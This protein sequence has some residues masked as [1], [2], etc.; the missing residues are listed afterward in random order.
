MAR[1]KLAPGGVKRAIFLSAWFY[2][3][4]LHVYPASFRRTYGSRMIRVFRDSCRNALQKHGLAGF[5]ILWLST[6]T[7]LLFSAC[8]ERWQVLKEKARSMIPDKQ[9]QNFPLRLWIAIAA[10][11]LAFVVSLVASLN[12]YLLEDASPLT[13]AAYSAS[14]LLRFDI[15]QL[16]V[17][18][19]CSNSCRSSPC[20]T[21]RCSSRS[22]CWCRQYV[23][24]ECRS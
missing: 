15:D 4:F 11:V 12:L 22:L 7:D 14:S 24:C 20:S 6:L 3:L 18:T 2:G 9:N 8:L 13:Q 10:T 21:I 23:A 1:L 19:S 16:F 5:V 17:R